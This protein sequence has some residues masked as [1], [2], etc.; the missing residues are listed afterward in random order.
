MISARVTL[1]EIR[2]L[3]AVRALN[4]SY[5]IHL[6]QGRLVHVYPANKTADP[7][8]LL[9]IRLAHFVMPQDSCLGQ[10]MQYIDEWFHGYAPELVKFLAERK[11]EWYRARG[12]DMP[13]VVGN[14]LG[15]CT[16]RDASGPVYQNITV[17]DAFNLMALRSLQVS[18]GKVVPNSPISPA[19]NPVSWKFRF[20]KDPAADTGIG[21]V[22]LF[23]TF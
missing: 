8:G 23:Q 17:R 13:G 22:A 18:R 11:A 16:V 5:R 12:R 7:V 2:F 1:R 4:P 20:R 6:V 9:D 15:N 3:T 14:M 19:Y 10:A 21:G